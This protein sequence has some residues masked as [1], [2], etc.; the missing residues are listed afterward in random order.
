MKNKPTDIFGALIAEIEKRHGKDVIPIMLSLWDALDAMFPPDD[1]TVSADLH[2]DWFD[3][4]VHAITFQQLA[5][6]GEGGFAR[7]ASEHEGMGDT[8]GAFIAYATSYYF[9][10]LVRAHKGLPVS[11]Q[12]EDRAAFRKEARRLGVPL[13]HFG[14]FR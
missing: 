10:Q 5:A 4:S 6:L 13:S 11:T 7:L 12:A 8:D 14:K 1:G 9:G 3:I 2:Q